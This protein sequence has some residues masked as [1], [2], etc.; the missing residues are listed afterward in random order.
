MMNNIRTIQ[1]VDVLKGISDARKS[2]RAI[3]F[4]LETTGYMTENL[5]ISLFDIDKA[6]TSEFE[7]VLSD[8]VK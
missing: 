1:H 2:I 6:L 7:I 8:T 3:R 4:Y 5:W